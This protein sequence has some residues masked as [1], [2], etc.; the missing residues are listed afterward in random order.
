MK[1]IRGVNSHRVVSCVSSQKS[2]VVRPSDQVK[3]RAPPRKLRDVIAC[4]ASAGKIPLFLIS[5][6]EDLVVAAT[7]PLLHVIALSSNDIG[8]RRY[9]EFHESALGPL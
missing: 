3:W 5:T 7:S 6:V 1:G 9:C 8:V 4:L 2:A